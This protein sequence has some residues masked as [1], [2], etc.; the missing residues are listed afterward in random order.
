MCFPRCFKI[1]E[2]NEMGDEIERDYMEE[3]RQKKHLE[4]NGLTDEEKNL[5]N[6]S[7]KCH[8]TDEHESDNCELKN[9]IKV[10]LLQN[11]G[12]ILGF[13][14]MLLMALYSGNISF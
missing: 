3:K 2:L 8:T 5:T 11:T 12:I 13:S 4:M 6:A 7:T 10:F 9:K 14:F 1:P